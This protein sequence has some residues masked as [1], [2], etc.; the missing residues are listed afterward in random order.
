MI[1]RVLATLS[2]LFA[3]HKSDLD[4]QPRVLPYVVQQSSVLARGSR[5]ILTCHTAVRCHPNPSANA[6]QRVPRAY[7][8]VRGLQSMTSMA[9]SKRDREGE[10]LS[11]RELETTTDDFAGLV[12]DVVSQI[13]GSSNVRSVFGE[14]VTRDE[15]TI[16][17]VAS[18]YA[19]FGA[20]AGLGG[21]KKPRA[22]AGK[23]AGMGVGGG[24]IMQPL[25]VWEISK[26]QVRFR[27]AQPQGFLS[28]LFGLATQILHRRS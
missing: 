9:Q 14:P 8:M 17:P 22:D 11:A 4:V 20:G 27:R 19:G 7:R 2:G 1:G 6:L 15:V 3:H 5:G 13:C 28:T 25:G 23:G 12:Q 16:I 24:F 10:K 18:V 26:G 21:G